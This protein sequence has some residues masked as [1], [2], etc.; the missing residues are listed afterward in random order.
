MRSSAFGLGVAAL[1]VGYLTLAQGLPLKTASGPGPG[2]FPLLVAAVLLVTGAIAAWKPEV[3]V[4]VVED[5]GFG[6]RFAV[7]QV[8]A[9]LVVF[10]LMFQRV[11]FLI[12]GIFVMITVLKA[13]NTRWLPSLFISIASVFGI[14]LVF[15]PLLG[16]ALPRG[17]WLP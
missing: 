17:S 15:V 5:A 13:F 14:Y 2:L 1:G 8:F 4:G 9:A 7:A 3:S 12:S 6:S 10:S 16:L 11:G